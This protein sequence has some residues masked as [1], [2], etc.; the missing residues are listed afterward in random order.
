VV[1]ECVGL[2]CPRPIKAVPEPRTLGRA[3]ASPTQPPPSPCSHQIAVARTEP[4]TVDL[5]FWLPPSFSARGE[6][7]ISSSSPP[8][9]D[10]CPPG[11]PPP[12]LAPVR[13][14]A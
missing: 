14:L 13:G 7:P 6:P 8:L 2:Y 9:S 11:P 1:R 5:E 10:L 12:P 4:A 3:R